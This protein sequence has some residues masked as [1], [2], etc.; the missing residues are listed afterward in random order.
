MPNVGG[1][2]VAERVA[3]MRAQVGQGALPS[4]LAEWGRRS[5]GTASSPS[6]LKACMPNAEADCCQGRSAPVPGR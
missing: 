4:R 6:S 5:Q 1:N 3:Q 2:V